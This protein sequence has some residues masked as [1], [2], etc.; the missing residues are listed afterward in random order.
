[1]KL[2]KPLRRWLGRYTIEDLLQHYE[3]VIQARTRWARKTTAQRRS[4]IKHIRATLA[5]L[6]LKSVRPHHLAKVIADFEEAGNNSVAQNLLLALR[7]LFNEALLLG[8]MH[9]NPALH[10][11]GPRRRITRQ[12]LTLEQWRAVHAYMQMNQPP[13]VVRAWLLALITGQRCADLVKMQ[14]SDVRSDMLFVHQQKKGARIAIPLRLRLDALDLSLEDV[15][16]FCREP[17]AP[18][19]LICCDRRV[20]VM[21]FRPKH[22]AATSVKPCAARAF[23]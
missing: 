1:M 11:R 19:A 10:V 4:D 13:W 9:T 14:W 22:S 20:M 23:L 2:P 17:Y 18:L 3:K 15:V 6:P 21:G 12:R 8:W 5:D 7:N 16:G